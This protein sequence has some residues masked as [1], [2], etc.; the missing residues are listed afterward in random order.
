[1]TVW[2]PQSYKECGEVSPKSY[3]TSKRRGDAVGLQ[4]TALKW[5]WPQPHGPFGDL[6]NCDSLCGGLTVMKLGGGSDRTLRKVHLARE[7]LK[8]RIAL[9]FLLDHG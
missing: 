3:R 4:G 1:M 2:E 9:K 7:S 8:C 5:R 6:G